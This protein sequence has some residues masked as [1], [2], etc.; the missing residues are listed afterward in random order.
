ME[1]SGKVANPIKMDRISMSWPRWAH[2]RVHR[3]APTIL[4]A[5]AGLGLGVQRLWRTRER[6]LGARSIAYVM[7]MT[8]SGKNGQSLTLRVPKLLRV[9]DLNSIAGKIKKCEKYMYTHT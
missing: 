9:R 2:E 7:G 3:W 4:E 6:G 1:E 8:D 5:R